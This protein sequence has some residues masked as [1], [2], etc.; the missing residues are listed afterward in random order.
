MT[1][2]KKALG[3]RG[4]Q[5][6]CEY[7]ESKGFTPIKRNVHVGHDEIDIIAENEQSIIFVEVKARADTAANKRYGRPASAVGY[8]KQTRIMRAVKQYLF[9][10]KTEI[11]KA[12]RIDVIEIYFPAIHED[13]PIDI[14]QLIPL[15]INH[16]TNAVHN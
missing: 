16:I 4:E 13:T 10:H 12:P 14:S 7:L 11:H 3:C 5:L 6:A 8:T 2:Y 15:K 9:D 1:N